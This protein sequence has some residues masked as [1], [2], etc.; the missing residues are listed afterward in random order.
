MRRWRIGITT[1]IQD[2]QQGKRENSHRQQLKK[3]DSV[4]AAVYHQPMVRL[5]EQAGA[6]RNV[7]TP[8]ELN[9]EVRVHI[10]AGF[11][12][13]WLEGEISNL[14]R[15]ASGHLYFSLKDSKAQ[16]RCALFRSS[17][18]KL[19]FSPQNGQQVL[20][21]GRVSLYEARGEFQMVVSHM[22]E[23]GEGRLRAE[24]EALKRKLQAEGLFAREHKQPLP[25]HPGRIAV[26]TSPSGAVIR[27]ILHV[28]ARR[29]PLAAV[30]LYPAAVQ[31]DEAPPAIVRALQA[32]D[33][34]QWA[35]LG[36]GSLEDLQAFNDERVARAIFESSLPVI[37]AVGHETDTSISDFVADAHAPTPSAAA[38]M[39][40]PDQQALR[41]EFDQWL[42]RLGSRITHRLQHASQ[43]LDHTGHRLQQQHAGRGIE[44]NRQRLARAQKA[45]L[46]IVQGQQ[47]QNTARLESFRARINAQHPHLRLKR[48]QSDLASRRTRLLHAG[49]QLAPSQQRRLADLARTLNAVSP[50]PT[51]ARGYAV[52]MDS[53]TGQVVGSA[54]QT[55]PGQA[56]TAQLVD[57][58]LHCR[59]DSVDDET[60]GD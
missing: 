20:A 11:P 24:F 52:V 15:P 45:L 40:V 5:I 53:E 35:E 27:D 44:L 6:A 16:V 42:Q 38:E 36:G 22:E 37:S 17:A 7:Y 49:R 29:W 34:H 46:A 10:E 43:H 51:L 57:G 55:A 13:T 18:L 19:G 41:R 56:V 50:L 9:H 32:A 21:R 30:R 26:V 14:S 2:Q 1:G 33:R 47:Q 23:S 39:A 4:V 48:L 25:L 59:V 12:G 28:L 60:L 54:Q 3:W 31:G 58:R 8:S